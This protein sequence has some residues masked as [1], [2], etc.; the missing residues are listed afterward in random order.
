[1][2]DFH[3]LEIPKNRDQ[4]IQEPVGVF[5]NFRAKTSHRIKYEAEV[6]VIRRQ[7]GDLEQIRLNLGLSR[8][9]ICQL[10]LVD[11]SAW[12]RWSRSHTAPPHI[13]RALQWYMSLLE[14]IPGLSHHYFL[15]RDFSQME[16]Q[17]DQWMTSQKEKQEAELPLVA[18][19]LK[20]VQGS[21]DQLKNQLQIQA[22]QI[23]FLRQQK[24]LWQTVGFGFFVVLVIEFGFLLWKS[25]S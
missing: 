20:N 5:K 22:S 10:L 16:K 19:D 9:K 4:K 18:S 6:E 8:R 21:V 12:T 17:I 1:M 23:E 24:K 3:N 7:I 13:Y 11:P 14:K 25:L 15:G 2:P